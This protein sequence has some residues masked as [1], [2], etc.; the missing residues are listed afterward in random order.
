MVEKLFNK[1]K[2]DFVKIDISE[3]AELRQE[4][5]EK[6]NSLSVPIIQFGTKFTVGYNPSELMRLL[7][8]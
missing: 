6:V 7:K 2:V 1:F 5:Y 3:N 8:S 4:L